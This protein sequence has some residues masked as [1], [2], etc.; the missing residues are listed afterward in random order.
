MTLPSI[1]FGFIISTLFG[2]IFHLLRGGNAGRFLLYLI[3]GWSGFWSGQW[4]AEKLGWTFGSLG[5]LH[6]GLASILSIVFLG[7]GYWLSLV[8]VEKEEKR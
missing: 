2:V 8:K 7:F 6:L 3:V 4:L 1:I 5:P